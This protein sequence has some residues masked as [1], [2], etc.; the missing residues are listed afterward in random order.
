MYTVLSLLL[1]SVGL[2]LYRLL[3]VGYSI[4]PLYR[5][6]PNVLINITVS[7]AATLFMYQ[8]LKRLQVPVHYY[9]F[10]EPLCDDLVTYV[11]MGAVP[12]IM[13][14]LGGCMIIA[15]ILIV[16]SRRELW[17]KKDKTGIY[18]ALVSTAL[19]GATIVNLLPCV[20]TTKLAW[21]SVLDDVR[22]ILT[23]KVCASTY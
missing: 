19:F 13:Q 21:Y 6:W 20:N 17:S 14:L 15:G 16:Y 23:Q 22:T 12:T 1:G 3:T 5:A 8:A 10:F 11:V 7:A 9:Q 4:P 18:Y 2:L